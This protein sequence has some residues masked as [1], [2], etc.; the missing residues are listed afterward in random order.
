M[1]VYTVHVI[2]QWQISKSQHFAK[3][4]QKYTAREG[5]ELMMYLT[6]KN[7]GHRVSAFMAG[8]NVRKKYSLV[9]RTL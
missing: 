6:N 4:R 8:K 9:F 3:Q 1:Y 2:L 7:G 5:N